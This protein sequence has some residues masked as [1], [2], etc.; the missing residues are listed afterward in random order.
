MMP[1][2]KGSLKEMYL[3]WPDQCRWGLANWGF[4]FKEEP[5]SPR[6]IVF[7]GMGGSGVVGDYI[8]S[9]AARR[10]KMP[11]IV[12]KD[13]KLPAWVSKEDLVIAVSYSGN[14]LETLLCFKEAIAR[15]CRVAAISSG[16]KL[17]ELA[18]KHRVP[19][20][21]VQAGYV[22]RAALPS[23]LYAALSTLEAL[24]VPVV[25]KE[26]AEE[27]VDVVEEALK[28]CSEK[29]LDLEI[30][31]KLRNKVP[32]IVTTS[33]YAA[34]AIRAKNEFN[35]NSK[36]PCKV[37]VLPEWGHND[38]VGWE[39]HLGEWTALII[40]P[41]EEGESE[42]L[43]AAER[44]YSSAGIPMVKLELFGENMLA[45]LLYGSLV[46]GLASIC[47]GVKRSVDPMETK[48]I[49][50]FKKTVEEILGKKSA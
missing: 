10:L 22:P 27:A 46:I 29:D 28:R 37:E 39:K 44:V 23:M 14:T 32:V 1:S 20:A 31:W 16:G 42:L 34:L 24:G 50:E 47:L 8:A 17:K 9:I 41:R 38:V 2:K 30:A 21:G 49:A 18:E 45:K 15:G 6:C 26:E 5:V 12:V 40:D 3:S 19:W 13:Y 7:T 25:R 36:L 48:Y 4:G 33:S 43:G 11:I 35:E